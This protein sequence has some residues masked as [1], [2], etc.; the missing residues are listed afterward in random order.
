MGK[1]NFYAGDEINRSSFIIESGIIT[2]RDLM[3]KCHGMPVDPSIWCHRPGDVS[4]HRIVGHDVIS[5]EKW[6]PKYILLMAAKEPGIH[7]E[8]RE[9]L[10]LGKLR[11]TFDLV[12]ERKRDILIALNNR[13]YGRY[14]VDVWSLK[15]SRWSDNPQ[16]SIKFVLESTI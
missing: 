14:K 16:G 12:E 5:L 11:E 4:M 13:M 15:E 2:L 6:G 9:G 10:S 3:I 1:F 7:P 8:S